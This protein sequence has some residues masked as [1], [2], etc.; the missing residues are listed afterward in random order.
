MKNNVFSCGCRAIDVPV[1]A[2][3]EKHGASS[4]VLSATSHVPMSDRQSERNGNNV[5]LYD[6]AIRG[7]RRIPTDSADVVLSYMDPTLHT[8]RNLLPSSSYADLF[9]PYF[10]ECMRIL[11]SGVVAILAEPQTVGS[12]LYVAHRSRMPVAGISPISLT[13]EQQF[14]TRIGIIFG[15]QA[16]QFETLSEMVDIALHN[17]D[18][19][20]Y[21]I[22]PSG[23]YRP[24]IKRAWEESRSITIVEDQ[25]RFNKLAS[26]LRRRK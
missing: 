12:I 18:N 16:V 2:T 22:D 15:P 1:V 3:C 6:N 5:V 14:G 11:R 10:R 20:R 8:I 9:D 13:V 26:S 23:I 25:T 17:H 24:F 4:Y 21:V 19:G 7:M